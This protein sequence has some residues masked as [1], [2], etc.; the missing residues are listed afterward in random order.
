MPRKD[1]VKVAQNI[2]KNTASVNEMTTMEKDQKV[3]E[4]KEVIDTPKKEEI[5]EQTI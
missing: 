1:A 4:V 3:E 2:N 5:K